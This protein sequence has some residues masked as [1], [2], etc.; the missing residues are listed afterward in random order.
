MRPVIVIVPGDSIITFLG[1]YE[2]A[3]VPFG[4]L[5]EID[6]NNRRENS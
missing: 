5:Y 4:R 6:N 1:N 2:V 3:L